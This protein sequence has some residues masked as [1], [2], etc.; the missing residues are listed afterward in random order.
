VLLLFPLLI[1]REER[2]DVDL[3]VGFEVVAA[4]QGAVGGLVQDHG[5]GH[6]ALVLVGDAEVFGHDFGIVP[7]ELQ[8]EPSRNSFSRGRSANGHSEIGLRGT[9]SPTS[10]SRFVDARRW[11]SSSVSPT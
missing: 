5:A 11:T 2:R 9:V 4:D 6:V 7:F 10:F 3:D 1:D 8:G